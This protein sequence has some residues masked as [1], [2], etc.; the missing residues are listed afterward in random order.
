M[1]PLFHKLRYS[2][3]FFKQS[4]GATRPNCPHFRRTVSAV[5]NASIDN[6]S[7]ANAFSTTAR[8]TAESTL[9]PQEVSPRTAKK[10]SPRIRLIIAE[11]IVILN[12]RVGNNCAT[13]NGTALIEQI[14][15][16]VSPYL[17]NESSGMTLGKRQT[18]MKLSKRGYRSVMQTLDSVMR[19]IHGL[20][21]LKAKTSIAL[22]TGDDE[23][24]IFAKVRPRGTPQGANHQLDQAVV[25]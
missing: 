18:H 14:E 20:K 13:M 2:P 8:P 5:D 22:P 24:I 11:I 10:L 4:T 12:C 19:A 3:A 16:V 1:K 21:A 25:D 9:S 23:G 15:L 7:T 17:A 6:D